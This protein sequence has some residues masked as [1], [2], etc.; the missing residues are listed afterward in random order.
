M[1]D[2]TYLIL[3]DG[4]IF[5]GSPFGSEKLAYG[6]V[7]FNTSMTGY[8]EMLTD[9]SY[10]GQ[11]VVPTYPMM[12]NYGISSYHQESNKVRKAYNRA[13]HLDERRK[14]MQWWSDHVDSLSV[15]TDAIALDEKKGGNRWL[16]QK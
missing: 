5:S 14:M 12:G 11:I 8:Q 15:S 6:E 4:S 2:I 9:P 3:E 1:A 10:A 16:T 7:V 13:E